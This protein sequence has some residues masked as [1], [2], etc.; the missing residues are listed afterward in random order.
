MAKTTSRYDPRG[1]IADAY[2]IEGIH[3]EECRSIFLDWALEPRSSGEMRLAAR[4]LL[5]NYAAFPAHPMTEILQAALTEITAAPA[6][7]G[8]RKARG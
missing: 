1:V 8:G 6:R 4:H 2:R 5:E 7:R 3:P